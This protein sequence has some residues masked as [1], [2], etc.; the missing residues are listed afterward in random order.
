MPDID[1]V[2][3][4]TLFA[5]RAHRAQ[6]R[7]GDDGDPYVNH[8]IEVA[9]RLA[10]ATKGSDAALVVAGLL[11]D[12]VEDC[13]ITLEEIERRFGPT[14]AALVAEVTDDKAL[15]KAERKRAQVERAARISERAR[16]IKMA[17][18]ASNLCGIAELPGIGWPAERRRAYV[19]WAD[20]VT[21]HCRGLNDELDRRYDEARD[22]AL[23]TVR[24]MAA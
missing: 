13:G 12:T 4:A 6:L 8:V 11:H 3:S 2:T 20:E 5:A 1:E 18:K 23:A 10:V 15:P 21:A 24:E 16:L 19:A 14:V 17:D 7:K 22:L 9:D